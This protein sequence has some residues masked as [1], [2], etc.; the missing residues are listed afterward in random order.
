MR[1]SSRFTIAIMQD[2]ATAPTLQHLGP[3]TV[4]GWCR[5]MLH[6][7][8]MLHAHTHSRRSPGVI[9]TDLGLPVHRMSSDELDACVAHFARLARLN[10]MSL[11][12]VAAAVREVRAAHV[13]AHTRRRAMMGT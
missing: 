8:R 5:S 7:W 13:A 4:V 9:A 10:G 11:E 1:R 12:E 2:A 6:G 3:M